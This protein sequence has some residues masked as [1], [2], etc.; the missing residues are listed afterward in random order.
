MQSVLRTIDFA[1][2][3]HNGQIRSGTDFPYIIHPVDV[4]LILCEHGETSH[5]LI[6]AA[7]LHDTLEDTTA[8]YDELEARFGEL[9]AKLVLE[10]TDDQSLTKK[11]QR[12]ALLRKI[13]NMSADACLLKMADGISNVRSVSLDCPADWSRSLKLAYVKTCE[14]VGKACAARW[15]E[16]RGWEFATH[17]GHA[18]AHTHAQA[19][20]DAKER[21]KKENYG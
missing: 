8:T 16:L 15:I 9:V 7:V 4:A 11:E 3:K 21:L 10:V 14:K 5:R 1:I 17:A 12:E 19:V 13:P 18:L 2:R 20:A 6:A